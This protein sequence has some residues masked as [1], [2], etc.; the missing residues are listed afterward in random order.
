MRIKE[1]RLADLVIVE[2]SSHELGRV[3][4]RYIPRACFIGAAHGKRIS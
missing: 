2:S 3:A 1:R 4:R